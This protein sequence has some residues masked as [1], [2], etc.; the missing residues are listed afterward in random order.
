MKKEITK[1][2]TKDSNVID[3]GF[4]ESKLSFGNG[5]KIQA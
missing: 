2:M 5:R 1:I 4:P 3:T